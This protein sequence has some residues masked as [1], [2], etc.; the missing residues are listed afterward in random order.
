MTSQKV[1]PV[2]N[3]LHLDISASHN[4]DVRQARNKIYNILKCKIKDGEHSNKYAGHLQEV[5][6]MLQTVNE[7]YDAISH[8]I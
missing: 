5:T 6:N 1:S 7:I 8:I 2:C 4:C 3:T